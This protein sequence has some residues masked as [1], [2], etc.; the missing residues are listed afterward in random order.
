[1]KVSVVIISFKAALIISEAFGSL[2][3]MATGFKMLR[4]PWQ[5]GRESSILS[6]FLSVLRDELLMYCIL[7]RL[8]EQAGVVAGLYQ[9]LPSSKDSMAYAAW[10]CVCVCARYGGIV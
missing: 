9:V 7:K 4:P 1:M 2:F 3:A 6:L 5:T 10:E 8:K